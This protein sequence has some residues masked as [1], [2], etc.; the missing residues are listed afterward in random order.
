MQWGMGLPGPDPITC[1]AGKAV[2]IS[3]GCTSLCR[4]SDGAPYLLPR[5]I[6]EIEGQAVG[7]EA[8]EVFTGLGSW[9]L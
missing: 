2:E 8:P 4:S 3:A 1:F 7:L 6:L 5:F 9:T